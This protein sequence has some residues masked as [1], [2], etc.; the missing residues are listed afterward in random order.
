[1]LLIH[2]HVFVTY[3]LSLPRIVFLAIYSVE[4]VIKVIAKGFILNNYTYLRNPW[5]WL[6]FIVILSGYLTSFVELGNLA[7][8]RTF[9]VLRALKTVSIMPGKTVKTV[10]IMPCHATLPHFHL[11]KRPHFQ[12]STRPH[13]YTS[14]LLHFQTSTGNCC[15][16][17]GNSAE[18]FDPNFPLFLLISVSPLSGL[19]TIINALLHSV[20]QLAEVMTL[21]VFCLMVFALFALQVRMMS[22][23]RGIVIKIV[24]PSKCN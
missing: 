15:T 23:R 19:K 17:V 1:M 11:S 8:L 14:T 2:S 5:N 10:Y 21:T 18:A 24:M 22:G 16:S 20:K 3:P 4:M 7:G 9:R 12:T 6:D 13:F